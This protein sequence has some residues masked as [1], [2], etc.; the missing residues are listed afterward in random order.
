M[1]SKKL[2][3][4]CMNFTDIF[5]DSSRKRKNASNTVILLFAL[6]FSLAIKKFLCQFCIQ[7]SQLNYEVQDQ[8]ALDIIKHEQ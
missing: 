4:V 5:C 2:T 1:C 8:S 6:I 7:I 3:A